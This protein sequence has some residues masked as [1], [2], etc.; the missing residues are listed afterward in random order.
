MD[1]FY[2][3]SPSYPIK[4]TGISR[5]RA[6]VLPPSTQNLLAFW[7]MTLGIVIY[8]IVVGWMVPTQKM[9]PHPNLQNL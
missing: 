2:W 8:H 7:P 6:S 4:R 9:Y 1:L 3:I 5:Y